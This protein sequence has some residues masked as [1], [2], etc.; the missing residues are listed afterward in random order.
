MLKIEF[1]MNHCPLVITDRSQVVLTLFSASLHHQASLPFQHSSLNTYLTC[2]HLPA[3]V[4]LVL[5]PKLWVTPII[6][7]LS[8]GHVIVLENTVF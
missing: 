7:V 6:F 4:C 1:K 3:G 5:T 2:I 8:R